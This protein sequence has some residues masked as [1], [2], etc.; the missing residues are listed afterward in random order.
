MITAIATGVITTGAGAAG[1]WYSRPVND[2]PKWYM[3]QPTLALL[4]PTVLIAALA[5]GITMI[6]YGLTT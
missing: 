1:I 2:Q 6:V 3:L 5:L 4:A